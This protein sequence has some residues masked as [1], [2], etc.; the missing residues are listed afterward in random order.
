MK[1]ITVVSSP[2]FEAF[3]LL[4]ETLREEMKKKK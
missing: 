1:S 3:D 2:Y 4:Y